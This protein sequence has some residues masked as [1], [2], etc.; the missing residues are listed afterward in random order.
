LFIIPKKK[1]RKT[2]FQNR[3]CLSRPEEN[4]FCSP[5]TAFVQE[6]RAKE[7]IQAYSTKKKISKSEHFEESFWLCAQTF[8]AQFCPLKTAF[9][10]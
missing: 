5:E 9:F 6:Q 10:R 3:P 1:I 4:C 2:D 7:N 8:F